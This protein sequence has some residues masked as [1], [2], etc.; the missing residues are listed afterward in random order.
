[1]LQFEIDELFG[2]SEGGNPVSAASSEDSID[3]RFE[4]GP[5]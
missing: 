3:E 4:I 2:T 5:M 1:M